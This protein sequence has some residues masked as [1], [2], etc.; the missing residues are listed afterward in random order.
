MKIKVAYGV[1]M[2]LWKYESGG[3]EVDEPV[4]LYDDLL[5]YICKSFEF[6]EANQFL[7]T[8]QDEEGDD[9]TIS[10]AQDFADAFAFAQAAKKKSLKLKIVKRVKS[11]EGIDRPIASTLTTK[12]NSVGAFGGGLLPPHFHEHG[13]F[14]PHEGAEMDEKADIEV[15]TGH[16][17][18]GGVR[19]VARGRGRG[20]GRGHCKG[21]GRGHGRR[22]R[23]RG[24][25]RGRGRG[26]RHH[27]GHHHGHT[28]PPTREEIVAFLSDDVAVALLSDLLVNTFEA[29]QESNFEIPL[30][31]CLRAMVL[32]EDKYKVITD[33]RVW[34][35]FI[36]T[37]IPQASPQII[38]FAQ[39]MRMN[40][41]GQPIDSN[42][43]RQWIPT[44]LNVMKENAKK[45]HFGGRGRGRGRG[46]A[47]GCHRGRRGNGYW[48]RG[49]RRGRGHRARGRG[50]VGHGPWHQMD[51]DGASTMEMPFEGGYDRQF[52][53]SAPVNAQ[54]DEV[55]AFEYTE[56]MVAIMQMGF[57]DMGE[58]KR[59]LNEHKGN[60]QNVVQELVAVQ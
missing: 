34:P 44:M 28:V 21:R 23:G 19:P 30:P 55:A 27:H 49:C 18:D 31:D 54:N 16:Q 43:V 38:F 6:G 32:S 33:N 59:L 40:G 47:R 1:D 50:G 36:N 48:G 58:I 25:H 60:K 22:G 4:D 14:G 8:F 9:S 10:C 35:F 5:V 46:R 11:V 3:D 39:M 17:D 42:V 53:P 15:V 56:E 13:R 29:V 20:R 24:C 51:F 37:L 45:G 57:S 41:N 7:V 12:P 26:H 52:V 2:R